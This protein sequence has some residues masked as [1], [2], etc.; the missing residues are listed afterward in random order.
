VQD[1][2]SPPS[3]VSERF[4]LFGLVQNHARQRIELTDPR[5]ARKHCPG[6]G[7]ADIPA[8]PDSGGTEIDVLGMAFLV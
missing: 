3:L 7:G 5:L 8:M 6:V 2:S 4:Q 1:S